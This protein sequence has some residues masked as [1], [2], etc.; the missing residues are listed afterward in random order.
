MIRGIESGY[1][2]VG[3]LTSLQRIIPKE[4]LGSTDDGGG[5]GSHSGCD[6]GQVFCLIF[7]F[8]SQWL[9]SECLKQS[10]TTS[11]LFVFQARG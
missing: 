11:S 4:G 3:P 2:I 9:E 6:V 1:E 10:A 7:L 8:G 5:I